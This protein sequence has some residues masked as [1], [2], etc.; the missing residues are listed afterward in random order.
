MDAVKIRRMPLRD[1]VMQ[2]EHKCRELIE[3]L[4]MDLTPAVN[5]LHRISRPKRKKSAFPSIRSLCNVSEKVR[6]SFDY[7]RQVEL[8]IA[9]F[10]Q[11]M[12]EK[13]GDIS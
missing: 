3:H 2:T 1:L 10:V 9:Q 11:A 6:R 12:E 4:Q 8:Q 5:E 13:V 7:A